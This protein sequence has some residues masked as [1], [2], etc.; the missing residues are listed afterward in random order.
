[1]LIHSATNLGFN[2]LV[3]SYRNSLEE[4]TSNLC[5]CMLICTTGVR[6]NYP[7]SEGDIFL[8]YDFHCSASATNITECSIRYFTDSNS[9]GHW[10]IAGVQCEGI[11]NLIVYT[12]T[13][14]WVHLNRPSTYPHTFD[15][16][17]F[18]YQ[19]ALLLCNCYLWKKALSFPC[20]ALRTWRNSSSR[21]FN[22]T[23]REGGGVY[24]WK[25]GHHLWWFLGQQR[26]QCGVQTAGILPIWYEQE[27]QWQN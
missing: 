11:R 8:V 25:L 20:S 2:Q 9:C 15:A 10:N 12:N 18:K 16:I 22:P 27:A 19:A 17:I 23:S 3:Y 6:R 21:L 4:W 14:I 24:Q 7:Y 13:S 5:L 26:C 1:M